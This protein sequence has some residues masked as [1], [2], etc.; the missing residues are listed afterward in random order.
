ML[1]TLET[2]TLPSPAARAYD[3][4]RQSVV[5]VEGQRAESATDDEE[6]EP[7]RMVGTG[8]VIVDTGVIL[9]NLHVVLGADKLRLRFAERFFQRT[10]VAL[11][12]RAAAPLGADQV[13]ASV[14]SVAMRDSAALEEG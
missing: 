3:A 12:P 13:A 9:T 5:L 2:K 10:A 6:D 14:I 7:E 11:V 1:H 8:L 4:V